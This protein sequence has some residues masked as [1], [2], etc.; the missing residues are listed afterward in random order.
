MCF[1]HSL[2]LRKRG[3]FGQAQKNK[4]LKK[5]GPGVEESPAFKTNLSVNTGSIKHI[6]TNKKT[7]QNEKKK[8]IRTVQ[9]LDFSEC[10]FGLFFYYIRCRNL[11]ESN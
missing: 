4:K 1:E 6:Y 3:M 7:K 5:T 9:G 2:L 10:G 8:K 11:F